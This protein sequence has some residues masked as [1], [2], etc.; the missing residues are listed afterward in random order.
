MWAF[1]LLIFQ[2]N[3]YSWVVTIRIKISTIHAIM[4]YI[5]MTHENTREYLI[6]TRVSYWGHMTMPSMDH[7]FP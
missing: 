2:D 6:Y 1:F 3:F 7:I 5:I 4:A